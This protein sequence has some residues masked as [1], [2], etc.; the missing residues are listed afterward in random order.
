MGEDSGVEKFKRMAVRAKFGG[1]QSC[2]MRE[3]SRADGVCN[4]EKNIPKQ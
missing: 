3:E 2:E 4:S 1:L